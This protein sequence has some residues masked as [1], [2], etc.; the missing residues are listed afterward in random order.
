MSVPIVEIFQSLQLEG[1][2]RYPAIFIRSGGCNFTCKGFGCKKIAPD[3]TEVI[4]CDTIRAVSQKFR[5]Q[6]TYYDKWTDL[7][8]HIEDDVMLPQSR[9]NMLKPDIVW[10]GGESTLHWKDEVMQGTL[11][12]F[13]NKGHKVTIETNGS[14]HIEFT[15]NYQNKIMFS[16]S[17]KLSHSGEPATKR[18]NPT[19]ITNI[20]EHC[21]DSYLK[22]V[23]NPKTWDRD[24]EEI[25]E[26][27]KQIDIFVDVMLMPLGGTR[28]ELLENYQ[29]VLEKCV[30][31]KFLFSGRDHILAWDTKE[32]V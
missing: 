29:F 30:E 17:V 3:G 21:P 18:F 19:N 23:I 8:K 31:H 13:I 15:R 10:T 1:K 16:M 22:F 20:V 6:W 7:V 5:E 27:L 24:F 12:Y 32:G 9:W 26:F 4:G 2:R 28:D 25:K 14:I 11:Q